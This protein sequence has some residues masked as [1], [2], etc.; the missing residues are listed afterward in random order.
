MSN[1]LCDAI[2]SLEKRVDELFGRSDA[3]RSSGG[4]PKSETDF[5]YRGYMIHAPRLGGDWRISK[6][7]SHISYARSADDARRQVDQIA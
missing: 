2:D 5:A 1:A 3:K 7:G 6:N 4:M